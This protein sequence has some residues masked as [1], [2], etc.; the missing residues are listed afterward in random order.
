[1]VLQERS[2]NLAGSEPTG[3]RARTKTRD[4]RPHVGSPPLCRVGLNMCW[5]RMIL[6]GGQHV[7]AGEQPHHYLIA[8]ARTC[9]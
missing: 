6:D 4:F 1:M 2:Q 9:L 3:Q 5:S 7:I 8:T